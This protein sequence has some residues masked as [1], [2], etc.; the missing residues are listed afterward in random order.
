MKID[1]SG[2]F[3]WSGGTAPKLACNVKLSAV[4]HDDS[5][6]RDSDVA[7]TYVYCP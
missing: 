7:E 2:N 5:T 3:T 6:D 1:A 4:A